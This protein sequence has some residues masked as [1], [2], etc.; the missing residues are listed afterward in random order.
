MAEPLISRVIE[1]QQVLTFADSAL[2]SH[3]AAGEIA[4]TVQAAVAHRGKAALGLATGATPEQTYAEL[5]RRHRSGELSFAKVSTYNLDEYYP[6]APLDEQSYRYY[7]H[8]RLFDHVDL[9]ANGMHVLDGTVPEAFAAEACLAFE[10]WIAADGGLDLQLLGIGRNGHIGF[11]EPSDL[12]LETVLALGT[13]K[14][15]LHDVTRADAARVFGS[16]ARVP[17]WALTMGVRTIL[18]ARRIVILAFGASKAEAVAGAILGPRT[19][20]LPASL[21]QTVAEKVTW[22]LDRDAAAGL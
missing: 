9:E 18:A 10:R 12:P 11:N 5:V 22:M 19:P 2:A 16:E 17:R 20:L 14:V 8:K 6:I 13:R 3:A 1:G 15:G 4:A 21:L 7:M